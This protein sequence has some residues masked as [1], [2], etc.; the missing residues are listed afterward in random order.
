MCSTNK[1]IEKRR[2]ELAK[3]EYSGIR[4]VDTF[5][6]EMPAYL[7]SLYGVARIGVYYENGVFDSV[8]SI[9]LYRPSGVSGIDIPINNEKFHYPDYRQELYFEYARQLAGVYPAPYELRKGANKNLSVYTYWP[10]SKERDPKPS[11]W[12][13]KALEEMIPSSLWENVEYISARV[14]SADEDHLALVGNIESI[15]IVFRSLVSWTD[16]SSPSSDH[17]HQ[18]C[19][20]FTLDAS[21][22]EE[23]SQSFYDILY[24]AVKEMQEW[25]PKA[26]QQI[27][28]Y[29]FGKRD[30]INTDYLCK[31]PP[32]TNST[33]KA[34]TEDAQPSNDC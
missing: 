6:A 17:R 8:D 7:K 28:D 9:C 11:H 2:L 1:D 4:V 18:P 3:G 22:R 25:Y 29:Y 13:Y 30:S 27:L 5:L 12:A 20:S 26:Q 19:S 32:S 23:A 14:K 15:E 24:H 31:K 34:L 10:W 33:S 16:D 21:L